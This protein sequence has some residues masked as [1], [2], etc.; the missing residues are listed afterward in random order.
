MDDT[1]TEAS[2]KKS[3]KKKRK[4]KKPTLKTETLEKA[5]A[6]SMGGGGG[7]GGKTCNGA[8]NGGRKATAGA[9]CSVLLT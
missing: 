4:Y 1:K 3:I 2:S 7:G 6:T 8:A 9:G 5:Y